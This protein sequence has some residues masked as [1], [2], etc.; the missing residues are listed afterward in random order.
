MNTTD[1]PSWQRTATLFLTT[2]ALSLFGSML[3]QYAILWHIT[4]T[5][6]SG[7]MMMLMII[8]GV[9][10]MF[11]LSPFAGV[12]A[13]RYDRKKLIMLADSL[14]ALTTLALALGLMLGVQGYWP[15]LLASFL[16]AIGQG[17]QMPAVGAFVP[18]FTPKDKLT[19]VN[20]IL[21]TIQA[22]TML[23]APMM[24]G[25]LMTFAPIETIFY[26]DVVTAALA[27]FIM[28]VF[29]HVPA[30]HAAKTPATTSY[31][32]DMRS[33]VHYIRH[34]GYLVRFF[35]FSAVFMFLAA[36]VAFL[37]PLQV[38]RSFGEDVWRLTAIEITFSIGMMIGGALIASW[39]G[40]RNRVHTMISSAVVMGLFTFALGVV[41]VFWLYLIFMGIAGL[42]MP[43]FN[44][45]ATVLI[46]EHVEE[47]YMGRVFSVMT[48]I[49]SATM[50]MGMLVF[51][52][53]ADIVRIEVLLVFTGL[54]MALIGVL[55]L[56]SLVLVS[57]GEPA[58]RHPNSTEPSVE[59]PSVQNSNEQ[60]MP[61]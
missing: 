21:G 38:T 19:R 33:G 7:Y 47:H 23:L 55:M 17:I 9:L 16:R 54:G 10:P 35:L 24:A 52:P 56:R 11:F 15:F 1:H 27:V 59:E 22:M 44:T 40:F 12:W 61:E 39:G 60:P 4:L 6:K 2:Q 37:S 46:Q 3:V 51:G 20:G 26:I 30:H 31:L 5:A 36:P 48:M 25:A 41:P 42:A 57:A 29:I 45:P 8:I 49:S 34:H 53:L 50:P 58:L 32:S 13:D 14:V 43:L 18:Q 28:A